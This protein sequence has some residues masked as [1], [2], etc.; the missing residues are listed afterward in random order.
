MKIALILRGHYR[1]FEKVQESWKSALTNCDYDCFFHTW[2]TID[3]TTKSWCKEAQDSIQLDNNK[4]NILKLWDAN[5]IIDQQTY[6]NDELTDIYATATYKSYIY[7]FESLKK[8]LDRIDETKYDIILVGRYDLILLNINFINDLEINQG[9]IFIG[10]RGSDNRFIYNLATS[11]CLFAFNSK[12]KIKFYTIP[13][14]YIDRKFNYSEEAYV[15]FYYKS[16]NKV[17]H[18]W[19]QQTH[20]DIQR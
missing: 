5:V 15:D 11:D 9:E 19:H 14:D 20:F 6:T 4:I 3:S 13:T 8:I 10:A 2:N 12:D 1:T 7:K 16:F 17:T 18:K